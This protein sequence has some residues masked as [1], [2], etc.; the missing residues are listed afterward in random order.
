MTN[1]GGCLRVVEYKVLAYLYQGIKDGVRPSA[2]KAE[3][4]ARV[5]PVY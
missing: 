2:A 3:E 4:V 5:S 1:G